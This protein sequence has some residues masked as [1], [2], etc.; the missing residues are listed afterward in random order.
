MS[1]QDQEADLHAIEAEHSLFG[2]RLEV[3]EFT[4]CTKTR[5]LSGPEEKTLRLTRLEAHLV[6]Y[7]VEHRDREVCK[8]ELL[9]RVWHYSPNATTHTVETHVW[10]LRRKIGALFPGN[11][12]VRTGATGYTVDRSVNAIP[13]APL[14]L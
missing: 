13:Q 11:E 5:R 3:P 8:S 7:L 9:S 4:V 14:D 12:L 1:S 6:A 2:A 10:R